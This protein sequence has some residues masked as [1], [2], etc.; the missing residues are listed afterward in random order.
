[1]L[2]KPAPGARVVI[3]GAGFGGLRAAQT[4]ARYP[5]RITVIDRKNHHTFQPLLYQV[6]TTMLSPGQVASP[7]RA[8][9]RRHANIDV[10]LGTV[11]AIDL[12]ARIVK[13]DG[14][15]VPYDYV[16]VAAGACHSYFGHAEWEALAPGLKTIEDALEIRRRVLLAFEHAEQECLTAPDHLSESPAPA[17]VVVGGGP[18]GVELAGALV[19][20]SRRALRRNFRAIDPARATITL[21]E[22]APRILP[23]F[24]EDL[25]QKAEE[26]LR[27]MGV[28]VRTSCP[29]TAVEPG[30]VRV[31][32]TVFPSSVT[33]WAAGVAASPLGRILDSHVDRSG[34]VPVNADLTLPG[35]PEVYVIGDLSVARDPAGDPLPGL[36]A[37]AVQEGAWAARNIGRDLAGRPRIPFQYVDKGLLATIGRKAA[38]A[39]FGRI[40]LS[41]GIAWIAWLFV[42]ILLLV[43]F[44]NR[45]MV[46]AEWTWSYFTPERSARLITDVSPSGCAREGPSI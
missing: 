8:I 15:Q 41:G 2:A 9:L 19:E 22:A 6:A 32:E 5:V 38:V 33:L 25:S 31:G 29:V 28:D 34:R 45:A 42:H 23:T 10:L 36:A 30:G 3:I 46:L 7:I 11:T 44:R 4:L 43:G 16:I 35:H 40:H 13:L 21:L 39:E 12:H 20:L 18:T 26:Q 14:A 1:M 17:F 37:V 24:P 27:A